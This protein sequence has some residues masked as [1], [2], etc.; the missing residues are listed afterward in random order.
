MQ[1]PT[2]PGTP[3]TVTLQ[4]NLAGYWVPFGIEASGDEGMLG[5]TVRNAMTE[6]DITTAA[7]PTDI[8][9]FLRV[10]NYWGQTGRDT[11][12]DVETL[13]VLTTVL[14]EHVLAVIPYQMSL[15]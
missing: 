11:T 5:I 4:F 14:A 10:L 2:A 1:Q 8:P 9:E 15:V 6:E 7:F 12:D 13:R 3:I